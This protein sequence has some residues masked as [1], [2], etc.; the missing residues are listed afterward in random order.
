MVFSVDIVEIKP[1]SMVRRKLRESCLGAVYESTLAS[2][3]QMPEI[4]GEFAEELRKMESE[5]R[6]VEREV[7]IN[8]QCRGWL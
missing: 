6:D 3:N 8:Q 5:D 7:V 2:N 4:V 1:G